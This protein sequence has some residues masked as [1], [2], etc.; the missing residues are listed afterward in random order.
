MNQKTVSTMQPLTGETAGPAVKLLIS[1]LNVPSIVRM[2][3]FMNGVAAT[4]YWLMFFAGTTV[5]VDTTKPLFQLQVVGVNGFSWDFGADN[6]L[7]FMDMLPL[8]PGTLGL[9]VAVS[10]TADVLTASAATVSLSVT[11]TS[12]F[13]PV[14]GM[15]VAGNLTSARQNIGVW[16]DD[17]AYR[18]LFHIDATN[19]VGD[20]SVQ[21]LQLFTAVPV[22]G[23]TLPLK[24]WKCA[25][26]ASLVLDFGADG[27]VPWTKTAAGVLHTGCGLYV[28]TTTGLYTAAAGTPW[29]IRA[30]YKA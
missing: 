3:G 21:Y 16:A 12:S 9:I 4:Q 1:R 24:Q 17:G 27:F 20:A 13:L 5:P 19:N 2:D 10:S 22:S 14:A 23:T 25:D 28:S 18:K 29:T 11:V 26:A 6:G 15:S 7:D 8:F 30:F